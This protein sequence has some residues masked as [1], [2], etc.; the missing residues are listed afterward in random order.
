MSHQQGFGLYEIL[1]SMALF[2]IV[3]L[4]FAEGLSK[5]YLQTLTIHQ[6]IAKLYQDK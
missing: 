6:K 5:A 1:V 3:L 2:S 4:G